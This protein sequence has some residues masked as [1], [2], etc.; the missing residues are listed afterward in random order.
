MPE[1]MQADPHGGWQH[2]KKTQAAGAASETCEGGRRLL[3][4]EDFSL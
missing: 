4:L 3:L 2:W 1:P